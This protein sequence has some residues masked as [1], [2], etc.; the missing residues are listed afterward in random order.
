MSH[1]LPNVGHLVNGLGTKYSVAGMWEHG[2][3][4]APYFEARK[5]VRNCRLYARRWCEV[6]G[7]RA[8]KG[9]THLDIEGFRSRLL[10]LGLSKSSCNRYLGYLKRCYSLAIRE[11]LLQ[12]N[13]VTQVRQYPEEGR[14]RWLTED[15]EAML[16]EQL[17]Q[18]G[19]DVV[20]IAT[21]TGLRSDELWSLRWEDVDLVRGW[22]WV[23]P[24]KTGRGRRIPLT[25]RATSTLSSLDRSGEFVFPNSHGGKM[26]ARNFYNREFTPAVSR[27]GIVG[28]TF[29][30]LRHTFCSRLVMAGVPL[31]TVRELAGHRTLE[32][33]LRYA[34]LAPDH[35][36]LAIKALDQ[37]QPP[38]QPPAT[39]SVEG[40]SANPLELPIYRN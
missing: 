31:N 21:H 8:A 14:M 1:T 22:L 27:A 5:N 30:D 25:D 3:H 7:H 11:G 35:H 38:K 26:C 23:R 20:V 13:P 10:Q 24:G 36:A 12:A 32:M 28:L 39:K 2:K 33:T 19:R 15:E 16:M 17:G 37:Q 9:L 29:H 34:H 4:Y 18:R 6:Y 40:K